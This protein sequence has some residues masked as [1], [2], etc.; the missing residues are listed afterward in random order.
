LIVGI[1]EEKHPQSG[2][3]QSSSVTVEPGL[4]TAK[5]GAEFWILGKADF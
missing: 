2:K 4:L 5:S 3:A 1:E